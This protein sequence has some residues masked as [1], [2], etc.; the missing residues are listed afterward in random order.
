MQMQRLNSVLR[1][2]L[3]TACAGL[4]LTGAVRAEN[5]SGMELVNGLRQGGYVLVMRHTSSPTALPDK[6]S[7]FPGN[8]K[9]ERQLDET[10]HATAR[11]MGDAIKSLRIPLGDVL[12]SPTYRALETVRFA[13]FGKAKTFSELGDGGQGMAVQSPAAAAD[14]LRAKSMERPRAGSN[15]LIVTH[16][17]N[18]QGAFG[19]SAAGIADGETMVF[20]PD[21][22][23]GAD[24]VARVKVDD[25]PRLATNR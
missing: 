16:A 14:W 10:G 21:G 11:A 7:A 12:S 2:C 9:L 20:L 25:W 13:A 19:Q 23:G 6:S 17:P 15:T 5:L 22:K 1:I 3:I 4:A 24:L 18:I 8:D